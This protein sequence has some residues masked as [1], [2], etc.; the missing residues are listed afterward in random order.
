MK[1]RGRSVRKA[2]RRPTM[3]TVV[4]VTPAQVA[5]DVESAPATTKSGVAVT[6]KDLKYTVKGPRK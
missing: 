5:M 2:D 3:A 6:M 4:D 1:V